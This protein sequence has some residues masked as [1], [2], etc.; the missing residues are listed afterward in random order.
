MGRLSQRVGKGGELAV[1]GKLLDENMNVF[2]PLID[3][4]GIDCVVRRRD[5]QY[6]EIQIKTRSPTVKYH[7]NYIVHNLKPR[8][9]FYI[10][11]HV[12]G[13]D[14][15]FVLPSKVF[16]QE[17]TKVAARNAYI[18]RLAGSR[19]DRLRKYLNKFSQL[20]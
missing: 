19:K 7:Y 17:S 14:E 18:L 3:V 12:K 13:T 6:T 16:A 4:E 2:Q 1:I 15:Y 8:P 5:G 11:C 20:T 10:V 9:N